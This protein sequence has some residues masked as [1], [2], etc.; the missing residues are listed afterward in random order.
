MVLQRTLFHEVFIRILPRGSVLNF[1]KGQLNVSQL[2]ILYEFSGSLICESALYF[3]IEGRRNRGEHVIRT[4]T[5]DH[6][7]PNL[8]A[9]VK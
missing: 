2:V 3:T 6:T 7:L 8:R 4:L 9:W 5:N 1:G